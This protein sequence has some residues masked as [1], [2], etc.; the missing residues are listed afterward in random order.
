MT[1]GAT[2]ADRSMVVD[3]PVQVRPS[4]LAS[5]AVDSYALLLAFVVLAA[6]A[7]AGLGASIGATASVA[8]LIAGWSSSWSP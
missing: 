7:V 4:R 1:A 3:D 6:G 5:V 8:A 2:P